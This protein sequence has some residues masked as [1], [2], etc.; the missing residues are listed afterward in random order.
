MSALC[1]GLT[2][3]SIANEQFGAL[4]G[5]LCFDFQDSKALVV[6]MISG[7]SNIQIWGQNAPGVGH[8]YLFSMEF[9]PM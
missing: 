9:A 3:F 4:G 1:G 5:N 7:Q 6:T 2:H 8:F